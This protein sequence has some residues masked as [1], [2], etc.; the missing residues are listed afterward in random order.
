MLLDEECQFG[1]HKGAPCDVHAFQDV[2]DCLKMNLEASSSAIHHV[3]NVGS[4]DSSETLSVKHAIHV[5]SIPLH[6]VNEPHQK[7]VVFP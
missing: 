6:Q 7:Y 3:I 1:T 4:Q 5:A 2:P